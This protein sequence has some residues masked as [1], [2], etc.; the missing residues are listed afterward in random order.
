MKK[1]KVLVASV[2]AS[3]LV[4]LGGAFTPLV[5]FAE[6]PKNGVETSE[7]IKDEEV[8][9]ETKS[10]EN[11]PN[12]EAVE[13]TEL[14]FDELLEMYTDIA[15]SK[16][17][18]G[19]WDKAL[20]YIEH[21]ASQKKVDGAVLGVYIVLA[22]FVLDRIVKVIN[23]VKTRRNDTTSKDVKDI[24]TESGQ[25]TKAINGLIDGTE[26]VE[27]KVDENIRRE[28]ALANA[29]TKQNA[30]IRGFIR[31]TRIEQSL[32]EEALRAL[33]ESDESC[34]EARK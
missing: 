4:F 2:L 10:V 31:G 33:N 6:E 26:K 1:I 13:D 3:A 23:Y 15:E 19:K 8:V 29:I 14:T 20:Y 7:N 30:A 17:F 27:D 11:T 9:E 16:G 25:Q 12:D 24:K 5:A 32:K 18:A 34:D 22:V 28:K 21:A